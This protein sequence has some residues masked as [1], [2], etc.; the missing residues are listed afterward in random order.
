MAKTLKL[1][2]YLTSLL[3]KFVVDAI[4][5]AVVEK[6]AEHDAAIKK[7]QGQLREMTQRATAAELRIAAVNTALGVMPRRVGAADLCTVAE[8][9]PDQAADSRPTARPCPARA[10][11]SVVG[12]HLSEEQKMLRAQVIRQ[13]H[14]RRKKDG[15][16][17]T[18]L[19]AEL[20]VAPA[21][22]YDLYYRWCKETGVPR[23][24]PARGRHNRNNH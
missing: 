24:K 3:E 9:V 1:L 18:T 13:F 22:C 19:A 5:Q 7:L 15:I 4:A 10:Q 23:A 2:E 6:Q 14:E 11:P 12:V 8:D 21:S 16:A 17:V 20:G